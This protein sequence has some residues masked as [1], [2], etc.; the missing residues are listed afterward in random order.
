MITAELPMEVSFAKAYLCCIW[1]DQQEYTVGKIL[2]Q[3]HEEEYEDAAK[4][5]K[6]GI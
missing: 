1:E 4:V 6:V 5:N 3:M 2:Q